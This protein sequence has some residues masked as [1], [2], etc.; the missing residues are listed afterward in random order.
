MTLVLALVF[1][2]GVVLFW[3]RRTRKASCPTCGL[4]F[5]LAQEVARARRH[6]VRLGLG[7]CPFDPRRGVFRQ[8]R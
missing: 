5:P 1:A 6:C 8:R 4:P 3:L 7:R 2:G